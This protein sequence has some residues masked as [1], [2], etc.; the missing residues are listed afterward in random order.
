MARSA[1]DRLVRRVRAMARRRGTA[2]AESS[3]ERR[4][5]DIYEHDRDLFLFDRSGSDGRERRRSMVLIRRAD[6]RLGRTG[7]LCAGGTGYFGTI[8]TPLFSGALGQDLCRVPHDRRSE[9]I[10]RRVVLA[11]V[12]EQGVTLLQ[13]ETDFSLL[14]EADRWLQAQRLGIEEIVFGER[15]PEALDYLE[16][17]GQLWRA[18]PQVHTEAERRE[19]VARARLR[20]DTCAHYFVS[21]RGVHW[22]TYPDF[23]RVAALARTSPAET[24]A[25]LREWAAL[26][27]GE[28]ASALRRPKSGGRCAIEFFGIAHADAETLLIPAL[29]RLLEGV[30]LGR[31]DAMDMADTLAGIAILF[32]RRLEDACYADLDDARTIDLLHARISD[33]TPEDGLARTDFDARRVALPGVTFRAGLPIPHP[34]VDRQILA[35]VDFLTRRLSVNERAEYLNV[36]DLRS[37]KTMTTASALTR[38]IVLKTNRT[39]TPISYIQKRLGSVRAGYADYLLTRANA[40]RALGADYPAFQLLTVI[41]H[42]RMRAQSPFFLRTR[43]PGDPLPAIAPERF[44]CNPS[45]PE[46]PEEPAVVL[47]LAGLYGSAA[48]Q[49]MVAKKYLAGPPPTCRFGIGKEIFE[50]AYDSAMHR[51]MPAHVQ[52]CSIRGTMGWPNLARTEANL[53]DAH[54][55]YLRSYAAALGRYWNDHKEACTLNECAT[56]FF[57]GFERKIETMHWAYNRSRA[58]FDGFDPALRKVYGFR[59]KWAFALWAMERAAEG[60]PEL[61]ERFM[62]YVRDGFVKA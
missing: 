24:V 61:R 47:A 35:V 48:A 37:T 43:A 60:L 20:L 55:F 30:T 50:F 29:E 39:P 25:C 14:V 17:R 8:L 21:V 56:A 3:A 11:S 16:C 49:N 52:V 40:F 19:A 27:P 51:L 41:A 1:Y 38:E 42:G 22:L 13:R 54:R 26:P 2:L 15:T 28:T 62:D 32:R 6:L 9:T 33:D 12:S 59:A 46:S 45:N 53:R 7:W 44:R 34:G 10:A 5:F 58:H 4:I 31:M 57:D 18:R 23:A 36:Y